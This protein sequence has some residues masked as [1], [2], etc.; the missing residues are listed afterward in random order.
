[1]EF[2]FH[3]A[4]PSYTTQSWSVFK[5]LFRYCGILLSP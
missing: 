5:E 1:M 2:L 4:G 3:V